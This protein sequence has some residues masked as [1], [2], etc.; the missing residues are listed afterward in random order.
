M[1]IKEK[2][3]IVFPELQKRYGDS[4]TELVYK[5][6]FQ[7]LIAVMLSAQTTDKRVNIV[8]EV[9]FAKYPDAKTLSKALP[10]DV[11]PIIQKVNYANNKSKFITTTARLLTEWQ[12]N[13]GKDA[14]Q[15]P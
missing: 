1:N 7:L 6:P 12:Q 13:A 14:S 5:T 8:T 2:I 9:L 4:T 11:L 3:E 15:I 10:E